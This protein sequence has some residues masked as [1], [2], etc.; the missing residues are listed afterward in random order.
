[1]SELIQ[2]EIDNGCIYG[3]FCKPAFEHYRVSPLGVTTG[4]YSHKKRLILDL[5]SPHS[6]DVASINDLIDK[7]QCSMSY[8]KIDDAV[9]II[10]KYGQGTKLCKFDI[11]NAIA[12]HKTMGP[13]TCIGYLIII[14]DTEKLE[15]RLPQEKVDIICNFINK[16]LQQSSCTKRELLQLLRHLNFASRVIVPGRSFVS[17]LIDLSTKVKELHYY[18]NLRKQCS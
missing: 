13:L 12:A 6:D 2:K 4:K 11:Q 10:T 14:L 5:S 16:V 9:K 17:Y 18:V 7:G 1:M 15:A 3:P 8:I